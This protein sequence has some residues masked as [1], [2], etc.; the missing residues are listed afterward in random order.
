[1]LEYIKTIGIVREDDIC[2]YTNGIMVFKKRRNASDAKLMD[3]LHENYAQDGCGH[4][5]DC[6]GCWSTTIG[7]ITRKGNKVYVSFSAARNF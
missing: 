6:C 3:Y 2:E 7:R 5:W 1:M 4:E